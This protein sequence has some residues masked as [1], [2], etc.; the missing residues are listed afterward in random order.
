[1]FL[2]RGICLIGGTAVGALYLLMLLRGR[3]YNSLAD[4]LD[5]EAFSNRELCGVGFALQDIHL[6]TL[7]G[8]LGK[9][10]RTQAEL[11]YG[12][13]YREYYARLYYARALSVTALMLAVM[14][15]I[16]SLMRG[17]M[18]LLVLLA[19]AVTAA[20][21]WLSQVDGM[22][23]LI[24]KRSDACLDEFPSVISKLALLVSSGMILYQAWSAVARSQ[25]G[26]IYDLMLQACQDVDN[27]MGESDAYYRF[28]LLSNSQEMRKFSSLLVQGL[29][30]GGGELT[31]FLMQQS[32]ELW[33]QKRQRMLQKGD[34]AAAKLLIPTSLILVGIMFIILSAVFMS[35]TF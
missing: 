23:Q 28:G 20:A 2:I 11:L 22:K 29:E 14:L 1:M 25:T 16:T 32:K 33:S 21:M 26:P 27:G 3:K 10:L 4:G 9:R 19:T 13:T 35:M 6:F 31:G 15:L 30:K 34:E 12:E 8:A 5:R 18:V 7:R 24:Q 17:S